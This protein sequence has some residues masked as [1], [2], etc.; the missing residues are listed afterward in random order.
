MKIRKGLSLLSVIFFSGWTIGDMSP[1]VRKNSLDDV[2]R[3]A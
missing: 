1:I 3:Q 2:G